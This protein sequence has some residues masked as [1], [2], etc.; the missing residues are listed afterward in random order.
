MPNAVTG[1]YLTS[2]CPKDAMLSCLKSGPCGSTPERTWRFTR[3]T[4]MPWVSTSILLPADAQHRIARQVSPAAETTNCPWPPPSTSTK[5][6]RQ[7]SASRGWTMP[8]CST[9]FGHV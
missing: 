4:G 8:L 9:F 1:V 5:A 3:D 2:L 6:A 7:A